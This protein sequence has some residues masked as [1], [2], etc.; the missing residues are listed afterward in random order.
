MMFRSPIVSSTFLMTFTL[1]TSVLAAQA[2][3]VNTGGL[4]TKASSTADPIACLVHRGRSFV[5]GVRSVI[6][7][8][9]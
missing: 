8:Q 9:Y 5:G 3:V 1:C 4:L 6:R 2:T 7:F